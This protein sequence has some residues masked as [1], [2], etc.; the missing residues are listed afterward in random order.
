[1]ISLPWNLGYRSLNISENGTIRKP[2]YGFLF[3]FYSNYGHIFNHF[4]DIQWQIMA[5]VGVIENGD[6][7]YL[8]VKNFEDMFICFNRIHERDGR[9]DGHRAMT[10]TAFVAE[11]RHTCNSFWK[12]ICAL[13]RAGSQ[14]LRFRSAGL[15]HVQWQQNCVTRIGYMWLARELICNFHGGQ[16]GCGRKWSGNSM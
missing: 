2:G 15:A 1:M 7:R 16:S 11:I 10:S 12:N 3:V 5:G 9:T 13:H 4:W 6:V 8:M 14:F